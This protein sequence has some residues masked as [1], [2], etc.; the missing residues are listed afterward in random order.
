MTSYEASTMARPGTDP[1]EVAGEGTKEEDVTK[2][3]CDPE[4]DNPCSSSR[5]R[6]MEPMD[7]LQMT[8]TACDK[9]NIFAEGEVTF[10]S[11]IFDHDSQP[12]GQFN[13]DGQAAEIINLCIRRVFVIDD[14]TNMMP[15]YH[16]FA[17]NVIESDDPPL[18]VSRSKGDQRRQLEALTDG[19]DS[20]DRPDEGVHDDHHQKF[21]L[22]NHEINSSAL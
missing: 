9:I 14:F 11:L 16:N 3:E 18:K 6:F 17:K 5:R 22:P 7:K 12:P 1:P 4:S 19:E 13:E 21:T 10:K 15:S 20:D 2:S 8:T